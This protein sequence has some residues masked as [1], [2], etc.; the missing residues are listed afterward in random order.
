MSHNGNQSSF[1][2]GNPLPEP[3]FAEAQRGRRFMQ[4]FEG[5]IYLSLLLA[6]PALI[7]ILAIDNAPSEWADAPAISARRLPAEIGFFSST[8]NLAPTLRPQIADRNKIREPKR[9][10]EGRLLLSEHP[11]T[12]PLKSWSRTDSF[13]AGRG[14][15]RAIH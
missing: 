3:P 10:K 1:T 13:S 15:T 7:W 2:R 14:D 6:A 5:A 11:G 9:D 8:Y 12:S 4:F